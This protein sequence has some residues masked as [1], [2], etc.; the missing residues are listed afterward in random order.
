MCPLSCITTMKA[1]S[2]YGHWTRQSSGQAVL[3]GWR[4]C[5]AWGAVPLHK[6]APPVQ[7]VQG[8]RMHFKPWNWAGYCL[9]NLRPK[10]V[11]R[12]E[13]E[14]CLVGKAGDAVSAITSSALRFATAC[15]CDF[16]QEHKENVPLRK[17]A[18]RMLVVPYSLLFKKI[19]HTASAFFFI[20]FF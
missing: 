6:V 19:L 18:D 5:P 11:S 1:I 16:S 15:I 14:C 9:N 12:S 3:G 2:I 20:I 4:H 8:C 7:A 10:A 13:K 17:Q